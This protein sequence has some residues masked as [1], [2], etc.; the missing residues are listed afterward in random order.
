MSK[1]F[2]LPFNH[3]LV[4]RDGEEAMGRIAYIPRVFGIVLAVAAAFLFVSNPAS[5]LMMTFAVFVAAEIGFSIWSTTT[6][7]SLLK[8]IPNGRAGSVLGV[9][10]AIIGAGLLIGSI[11]AGE[12]AATFGY[13]VTFAL[14]IAF[15]AASFT[16]VSKYFRKLVA[17]EAVA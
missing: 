1:V 6:T 15:L 9:N 4:A 12:V 17:V 11:A 3:R 2:F 8:M 7:T 14:A 10:S 16:L 13:G 5:I